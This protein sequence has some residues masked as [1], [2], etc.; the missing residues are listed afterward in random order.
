[1]LMRCRLVKEQKT[2]SLKSIFQIKKKMK[3]NKYLDTHVF[4]LSNF[5]QERERIML[6]AKF[7]EQ[8]CSLN[9]RTFVHPCVLPPVMTLQ[10]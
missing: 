7:K 1:M 4:P 5:K 3:S 2:H 6:L 9:Q 8:F 10:K